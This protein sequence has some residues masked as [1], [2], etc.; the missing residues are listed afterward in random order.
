MPPKKC[1]KWRVTH[2]YLFVS[3][4]TK[5]HGPIKRTQLRSTPRVRPD[6]PRGASPGVKTKTDWLDWQYHDVANA[7]S[8]K[9]PRERARSLPCVV[10]VFFVCPFCFFVLL[11]RQR[12]QKFVRKVFLVFVFLICI[13]GTPVRSP[14]FFSFF[15]WRIGAVFLFGA[16]DSLL[17]SQLRKPKKASYYPLLPALNLKHG[18]KWGCKHL[19]FFFGGF[20]RQHPS[21]PCSGK[22]RI[23]ET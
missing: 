7:T 23:S 9:L 15:W 4:W 2:W 3:S 17:S 11:L 16:L 19:F 22:L 10:V 8:A 13:L 21:C 14:F 6:S 18:R 5:I 12:N 1:P 20:F